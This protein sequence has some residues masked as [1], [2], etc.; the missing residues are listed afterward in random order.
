MAYLHLDVKHTS[1]QGPG[2]L[3]ES[4]VKTSKIKKSIDKQ[5]TIVDTVFIN[6]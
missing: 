2:W 5:A 1:K 4:G 3:N 6:V